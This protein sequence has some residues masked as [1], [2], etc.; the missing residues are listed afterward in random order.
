MS[1]TTYWRLLVHKLAIIV[2]FRDREG[3]LK[4]FVPHMTSYLE[5]KNVDFDIFVVEQ[6]DDKPF[7]RAKLLNIGFAETKDEYDY[8]CFHDV[9][10]LPADNNC[11]YS[12]CEGVCKLSY[13][14]SQFNFTPRP[15][16]E[17]GGVTMFDRHSYE[18]V[19]G[20]SND[21]WGWGV[22]D[23]DLG[24][25]CR[26]KEIPFTLRKGKYVSLPHK[27]NGDTNGQPASEQTKNNRRY[28]R[29]I[30]RKEN[31]FDSGLSNLEY[32]LASRCE[33]KKYTRISVSL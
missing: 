2:P 1:L 17:L 32:Q 30:S 31:F 33:N 23:N 4:K 19:N 11:D 3:H 25:R 28:Y 6:C 7:N 12:F 18:L 20:Y 8:F 27:P 24:E 5:G 13:Y 22:E 10:L 15:T 9:D 14:V 21:Y 29:D 16:S 26:R